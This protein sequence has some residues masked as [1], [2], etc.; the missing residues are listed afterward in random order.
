MTSRVLKKNEYLIFNEKLPELTERFTGGNVGPDR[1]SR[2][3]SHFCH[4]T[5]QNKNNVT[6]VL[7]GLSAVRDG[8]CPTSLV[9]HRIGHSFH[10]GCG[11]VGRIER[12]EQWWVDLDV[13]GHEAVWAS[14]ACL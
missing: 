8:P 10:R 11:I 4:T 2:R 7:L 5:K 9:L 14:L 6:D 1:V 3:A 13:S 12:L